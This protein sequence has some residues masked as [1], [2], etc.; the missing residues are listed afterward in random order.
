MWHLGTWFYGKHGSAGL[1]V[2]FNEGR[3]LFQPKLFYDSP[4]TDFVPET[5]E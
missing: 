1:E 2:G 5:I 3:G 4:H